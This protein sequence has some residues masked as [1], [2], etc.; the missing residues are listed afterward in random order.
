MSVGA[1]V[2]INNKPIEGA[3][4]TFSLDSAKTVGSSKTAPN[5]IAAL[6]F[7]LPNDVAKG[8]HTIVADVAA[9]SG[10]ASGHGSG[11]FQVADKPVALK[12]VVGGKVRK[13]N[14][15]ELTAS[16]DE[17]G[18]PVK[19]GDAL[20][21]IDGK[22]IGSAPFNDSGKSP[23][24]KWTVPLDAS[25]GPHK[26][27]SEVVQAIAFPPESSKAR[28]TAETSIVVEAPVV[29]FEG[30]QLTRHH[31]ET[32]RFAGTLYLSKESKTPAANQDV[33]VSW[34]GI[35]QTCSTKSDAKGQFSCDG[36]AIPW[37]L[38]AGSYDVSVALKSGEKALGSASMVVASDKVPSKLKVSSQLA[39]SVKF[40]G[41]YEVSAQL[42]R[43]SDGKG[44]D[45]REISYTANG[46]AV[47]S[48]TTAGGWARLAFPS[49]Q[50]NSGT[51]KVDV[52]F[53]GDNLYLPTSDSFSFSVAVDK[54]QAYLI[55]V[56]AP[57]GVVGQELSFQAQL[58][59]QPQSIPADDPVLKT[60][61]KGPTQDMIRAL[62]AQKGIP[63][64]KLHF[65]FE[66]F[67]AEGTTGQGGV[68]TVSVKAT[69]ATHY[70]RVTLNAGS[71]WKADEINTNV[72][73][74]PAD[75]QLTL[76]PAAGNIGETVTL[77]AHAT[78]TSDKGPLPYAEVTF[79]LSGQP[80]GKAKLNAMGEATLALKLTSAMGIGTH[81]IQ[82]TTPKT[83]DYKSGSGK[84]TIQVGA[85]QQ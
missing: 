11:M 76:D 42:T 40:P 22:Y 12:I 67:S 82:L 64:Q 39:G 25:V 29:Y 23:S 26:V 32:A 50:P 21:F 65:V 37:S 54:Q 6:T 9:G 5:G 55:L 4:I 62:S 70:L 47:G 24:L 79:S 74:G 72:L 56:T 80:L 83:N 20:F 28:A 44:I 18:V 36:P 8:S 66:G 15:L 49:P 59:A 30:P 16:A 84:G 27:K 34:K 71:T 60:I 3:V 35:E 33:V 73:I 31:Q 48:A 81:E 43:E 52:A 57:T 68:A 41:G 78:R 45:G 51:L 17:N 77:R 53:A 85:S 58:T 46:N 7:M 38:T 10:H 75:V 19:T 61:G 2:T 63:N 69:S 1:A 14:V 13:G